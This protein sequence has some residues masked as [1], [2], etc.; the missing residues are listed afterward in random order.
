MERIDS[1]ACWESRSVELLLRDGSEA[2][3]RLALISDDSDLYATERA[4][5]SEGVGVVQGIEDLPPTLDQYREKFCARISQRPEDCLYAV[6]SRHSHSVGY[7]QIERIMP[8]RLRHVGVV[9]VGVH[10]LHQGLGL[11]RALMRYALSWATC[12]QPP[13]VRLELGVQ[14]DNYRARR[15]YETLGFSRE[16][17]RRRFVRNIRGEESDDDVMVLFIDSHS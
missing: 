8:R 5:I 10:P 1:G 13:L 12:V 3:V 2:T 7:V 11:G 16:S 15:L 17:T 4:I 9:S 14:C 6:G